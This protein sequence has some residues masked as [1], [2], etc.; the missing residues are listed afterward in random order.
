MK[1]DWQKVG[2][3]KLAATI[4][5]HLQKNDIEVVLVGGACVSLY[6]DNQYMSFDIDL[7]TESSIRKIIPV[8]EELGFKN[9]AGRLF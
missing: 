2:I 4:S 1:I 9:T 5:A 6:T 7:I 8:L 3:K